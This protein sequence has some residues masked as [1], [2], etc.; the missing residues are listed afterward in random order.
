MGALLEEADAAH[1]RPDFVAKCGIALK[2][3]RESRYWLRILHR[4]CEDEKPTIE[5]LGAEATEL[6]AILTAIVKKTRK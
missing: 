5:K 2:E 3:A 1:S 6:I 4:Q